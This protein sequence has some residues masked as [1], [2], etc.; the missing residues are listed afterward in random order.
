MYPGLWFSKSSQI[1]QFYTFPYEVLSEMAFALF[2]YLVI[3]LLSLT[4]GLVQTLF[5]MNVSLGLQKVNHILLL[6]L[7][8][9]MYICTHCTQ[10]FWAKGQGYCRW[11]PETCTHKFRQVPRPTHLHTSTQMALRSSALSHCKI[12]SKQASIQSLGFFICRGER[13]KWWV[14]YPQ[15]QRSVRHDVTSSLSDMHSAPNLIRYIQND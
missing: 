2:I 4:Q 15:H 13:L 3:F 6:T 14:L 11:D 7:W 12:L 8:L 1:F 10:V 9:Y 5:C